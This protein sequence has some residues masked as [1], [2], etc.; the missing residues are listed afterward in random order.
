VLAAIADE[1]YRAYHALLIATGVDAGAVVPMR[2]RDVVDDGTEVTIQVHGTKR[3][4]RSGPR[5]LLHPVAGPVVTAWLRARRGDAPDAVFSFGGARGRRN[6]IKQAIRT[7]GEVLQAAL[8]VLAPPDAPRR[9]VL[10]QKLSTADRGVL[11]L[12]EDYTQRDHRHT[13]ALQALADGESLQLVSKQLG[14]ED[15]TLTH[16]VY[17]RRGGRRRREAAAAE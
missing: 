8:W 2:W 3:A 17:G 4:W 13:F 12:W 10:K 11:E 9:R 14:H 16:R 6:V 1:E 7:P 15:T 5:R